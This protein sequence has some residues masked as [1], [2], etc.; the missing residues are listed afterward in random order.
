MKVRTLTTVALLIA[1]GVIVSFPPFDFPIPLPFLPPA[2]WLKYTPADI[3]TLLGSFAF[4]PVAGALIA[5][6][7]AVLHGLLTGLRDGP[8]GLVMDAVSATAMAI[9]AGGSYRLFKTRKGAV[10]SL[11]IGSLAMTIVAVAVNYFWSYPTYGVPRELVWTTALPFN[12]VKCLINST[13]VFL[14]YKPLSSVLHGRK[15]P[16]TAPTEQ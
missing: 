15:N 9:A 14:L 7:R 2:P 12:L 8:V 1:L 16:P 3:P 4:G 10:M 5:V 11:L 13:F 6:A